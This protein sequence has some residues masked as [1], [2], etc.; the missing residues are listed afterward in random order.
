MAVYAIKPA[1]QRSLGG[2]EDWLVARRVHPD[3]LTGAALALAALG[4]ALLWAGAQMPALLLFVP[5][6]ALGRTTLNA[7]D[8]LVARRTGL[9]RPWGE[10]LNDGADRLADVVLLGGLALAPTSDGRLGAAAL[11]AVLLSSYLG[12]LSKAAGGPRQYGGVM[13]KADRMLY[14]ALTTLVAGLAGQPEW[15]NVYLAVVLVGALATLV[16]RG[17]QTYVALQPGR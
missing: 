2:V 4:G 12:V 14:L 16:Q 1:F 9:A 17:R 10:V 11:V 6:V 5:L 3:V 7:L 15:L 13:G 8:G